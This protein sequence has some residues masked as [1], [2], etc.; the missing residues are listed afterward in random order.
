MGVQDKIS[1]IARG[2]LV[3][4]DVRDGELVFL[5]FDFFLFLHVR[6][7]MCDSLSGNARQRS[8][9]IT[10][11]KFKIFLN[12]RTSKSWQILVRALLAVS[13]TNKNAFPYYCSWPLIIY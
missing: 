5:G 7:V 6:W 2:R 11:D 8:T 12:F 3:G 4:E 1:I 13:G 9:P 10:L